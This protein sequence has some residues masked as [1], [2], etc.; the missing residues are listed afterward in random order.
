[1]DLPL[2]TVAYGILTSASFTI[3]V[4]QALLAPC[5]FFVKL[6][7]LKHKIKTSYRFH[8]VFRFAD[9]GQFDC[10]EG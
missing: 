7:E 6:N 5:Q 2:P 3:K 4:T 1:M 10:K 9:E 8:R